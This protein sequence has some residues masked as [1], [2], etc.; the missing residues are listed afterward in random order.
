M[1]KK[2]VTNKVRTPVPTNYSKISPK[3]LALSLGIISAIS[4]F[5]LG[6]LSI[7][8]NGWGASFIAL[9]GSFYKGFSSSLSGAVIGA[10]WGFIDGYI[11]G[12]LIAWVYNK[13]L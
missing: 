2:R 1:A 4:I 9:I 8:F 12:L 13:F 3:A 6:I 10:I 11:G 5:L 7:L